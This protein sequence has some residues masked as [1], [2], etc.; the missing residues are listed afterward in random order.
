MGSHV[1]TFDGKLYM[2]TSGG[3]IGVGIAG[4][5]C[6]LYMVY[7]DRQLKR[8]LDFNNIAY[9]LYMIYV[10]DGLVVVK[11]NNSPNST[12]QKM[13]SKLKEIAN[14]IEP[15]IQVKVDYPCNNE[16]GRLPALDTEVWI[17][18]VEL[19][20]ARK[21]QILHSHYE[22]PFSNK[23]VIMKGSAMSWSK[24]INILVN[25]LL[26]VMR[27]IS[28]LC[29]E[30]ERQKK[31]QHYMLRLQMSGY[32]IKE[33]IHIYKKAKLRYEKLLRD[34]EL[35][36]TPLYRSKFWQRKE[37]VKARNNKK[38][39]WFKK[40]GDKATFF[41]EATPKQTLKDECQKI[42]RQCGLPIKVIEKSGV[43]LKRS[44]VR[45]NPFKSEDCG[46]VDCRMCSI[47]EGGTCKSRDI[48][49]LG[50]CEEAES[51]DKPDDARYYGETGRSGKERIEDHQ[52]KYFNNDKDS[53][54]Y[55][56]MV[57]VHNGEK[58][59]IKFKVIARC[60]ND[61]LLRQATEAVYIRELNP[62]LNRKE[63]FKS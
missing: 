26:R 12:G 38:R 47:I 6:K 32:D 58:K 24:K 51:E 27:N 61:A 33:R 8:E 15:S 34:N 10:D 56:H 55:N 7:W 59:R 54:F 21:T 11:D 5:I 36:T 52:R 28:V 49:Y 13:M 50:E 41:V 18:E 42:I 46:T 53:T 3:A 57:R 29:P 63:E 40:S 31:V 44:L 9:Q 23:L 2:Q 30:S 43:P 60:P 16:N 35:Q 17:E 48:V 20:G 19:D 39:S 14:C 37:R 25:D 45:S 62:G 22:K 4:D 1:F